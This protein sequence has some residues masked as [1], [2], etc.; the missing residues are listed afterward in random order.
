MANRLLEGTH[1][2]GRVT[3]TRDWKH[4]SEHRLICKDSYNQPH[5]LKY[6][7][8][9]LAGICFGIKT[10]PKDKL[11]IMR[12]IEQKCLAQRRTDFEFYQARFRT[13]PRTSRW[14]CSRHLK[15]TLGPGDDDEPRTAPILQSVGDT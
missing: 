11:R 1:H 5:A 7:F 14:S 3:K 12:I 4:E 2:A 6:R 15:V 8:K 9:D 10:T 13:E